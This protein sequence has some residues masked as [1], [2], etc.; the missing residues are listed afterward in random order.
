MPAPSGIGTI[1][2]YW[3]PSK[4]V[5]SNARFLNDL[6][7]FDKDNIPDACIKKL[8]DRILT[9]ENF[10]PE[11]VKVASSAC[12]GLCKWVLALVEYDKVAKFVRPK[13]IALKEAEETRD[14]NARVN[15]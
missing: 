13:K 10:D 5:L 15:C 3:G 1:E 12:A 4:K 2:D 6:L 14:V 9:N 8:H 11:R 7:K